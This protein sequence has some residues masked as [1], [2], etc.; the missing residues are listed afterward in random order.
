MGSLFSFLHTKNPR[1]DSSSSSET[2][3]AEKSKLVIN[4]TS[5]GI[6]IIDSKGIIQ[7]FNPAGEAMLGWKADNAVSLDFRSVFKLVNNAGHDIADSENPILRTLQTNQPQASRSLFLETASHQRMAASIKVSPIIADNGSS[8]GVVL[9]F[10]DITKETAEQHAQ[11]DFISTASHEMRTP[12]AI[13]EGYLGM[14]LNPETATIDARARSY[15]EKAHNSVKRLGSLFQDL[16]DVTKADDHRMENAPVL[17]DAVAA[18]KQLVSDFQAKAKEK[19]LYLVYSDPT[20]QSAENTQAVV[21]PPSVIYVDYDQLE[22][23]LSNIIDNAIKYTKTGG[24]K[25]SV[26]NI[27]K[28]VH[29]EVA[30]TGIG[31]PVEDIPH[32]FQKFYRIDNSQTREIG[33]TGLG[34]YLIKKLTENMGGT[35]GV[36]SDYGKGSRFWVEFV[37]L[38]HEEMVRCAQEMKRRQANTH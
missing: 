33:G 10:R 25:V 28:R 13:I 7:L 16:L 34:L 5:D 20:G 29:I 32:L 24:I 2:T 36:S 30:D 35:V 4:N 1:G 22:E 17:I 38:N 9:V 14:I 15:A 26:A 19:G 23:V 31:I 11:T 12:V 18:V 8:D 21:T 27:D 6:A 3:M 37:A